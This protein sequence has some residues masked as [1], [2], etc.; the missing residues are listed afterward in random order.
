MPTP[1]RQGRSKSLRQGILLLLVGLVVGGAL[2][3][4]RPDRRAQIESQPERINAVAGL[5]QPQYVDDAR[6]AGCHPGIYESFL[7][8][9]MGRSMGPVDEVAS[10]EVPLSEDGETFTAG[11]FRYE[12]LHREGQLI[13]A[14][15]HLDEQGKPLATTAVPIAYAVGSAQR[16]RSYLINRDGRLFMSPITWYPQTNRWDLSPGYEKQNSH[17]NRPVAVECLFCHANRAHPVEGT[18]A[19]YEEPI[20]SGYVIGCQRC[21]GPG[22]DH[23]A[24]HEGTAAEE[25]LSETIIN[26]ARLEP[27]LREAVCQQCHLSGAAKVVRRGKV[28]YDFRP[29]M[30][31]EEVVRIFVDAHEDQDAARFVGHVEQMVASRC[32]EASDGQMGCISCH[33]PHQQPGKETRISF[34]RSKCLA[35]H[36]K[37][38]CTEAPDIRQA[39][40]DDNC[41]QCHMSVLATEIR[42]AAITDHRIPRRPGRRRV[43]ADRD[44]ADQ[45]AGA[46]I[47]FHELQ[48]GDL[49]LRRDHALALLRIDDSDAKT[50]QVSPDLLRQALLDLRDAVTRHPDD[51]PAWEGLG[52]AAWRSG[53]PSF[54]MQC[55]ET[56]LSQAQEREF[57]LF[58]AATLAGGLGRIDDALRYWQEVV[59]INPWTVR[60]RAE[61]AHALASRGRWKEA[62][63]LCRETLDHFPDSHRS[64]HVLIEVL[65]AQSK[66]DEA[67]TEFETWLRFRPADPDQMRAWFEN[68]PLQNR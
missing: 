48:D 28:L 50:G 61:L 38:A 18:L 67:K 64:R 57:A 65:L 19:T 11:N 56:L 14:E 68:H 10:S 36:E 54:A 62:E 25:D 21:H 34:Y 24:L 30:P 22:E 59:R 16:G 17:F 44:A 27:K 12:I 63:L 4:S 8:H 5:R 15:T 45:P 2:L 39:A 29:G 58:N 46:I 66:Y 13:H 9:P 37:E 52:M 33:D 47:P 1:P 7:Q 51:L 6:C 49:E 32:F 31:L 40:G 3:L 41:M 26:P 20:F 55:F 60:Y 35:C 23:I 53:D 42:H 43:A